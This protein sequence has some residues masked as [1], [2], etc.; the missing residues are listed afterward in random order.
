MII[1][2]V[3]IFLLSSTAKISTP[4]LS[5]NLQDKIYHFIFY[6]IYGF[7]IAQA[8]AKQSHFPLLKTNFLLLSQLFGC[9][10]GLSDEVH[11]YFVAGR[12]MSYGDFL[13][14]CVGIV[15]GVMGYYLLQTRRISLPKWAYKS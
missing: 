13:A 9:L 11:Q 12:E 7:L 6:A 2:T 5:F 15:A 3:L 10:Y 4:D 8:F 14:N 1:Y